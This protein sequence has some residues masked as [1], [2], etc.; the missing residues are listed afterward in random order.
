QYAAWIGWTWDTS[1]RLLLER[2]FGEPLWSIERRQQTQKSAEPMNLPGIEA[3]LA[4]K[5]VL[6]GCTFAAG[7]DRLAPYTFLNFSP[8]QTT[9][10]A[11]RQNTARKAT[12]K[13]KAPVPRRSKTAKAGAIKETARLKREL[14]EALERQKATGEILAAIRIR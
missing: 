8:S 6:P 11:K 12:K 2:A 10:M 5:A 14:S 4:A 13:S 9:G 3:Q 7:L 1:P